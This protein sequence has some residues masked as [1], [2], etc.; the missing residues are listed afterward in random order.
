MLIRED[1]SG[2]KFPV[3]TEKSLPSNDFFD[4][5]ISH[6]IVLNEENKVKAD[7]HVISGM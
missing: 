3:R 5:P 7:T 2:K 1:L 4:L 6:F